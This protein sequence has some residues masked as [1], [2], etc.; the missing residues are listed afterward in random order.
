MG[1]IAPDLIYYG[2]FIYLSFTENLIAILTSGD[3]GE[4]MHRLIHLLFEHPVVIILRQAG[5][6]LLV[7]GIVFTVV[8]LGGAR[9][10]KALAFLYGWLGH[11]VL[12]FLTHADD[13]IPIF[14]PLSTYV[15]HSP[16]SYWDSRHYGDVFGVVN[17]IGIF[18]SVLYL[19]Y[20]KRKKRSGRKK[21]SSTGVD[22]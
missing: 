1:S 4:E 6:S 10:N 19:V 22:L 2:M 14:Y 9:L 3:R 17:L 12:D 5:H 7:W 13:A 15:F 20:E 16:I 18:G 21:G 8:L 11:I